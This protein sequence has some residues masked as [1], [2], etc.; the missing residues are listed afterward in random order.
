MQQQSDSL[1]VD[2]SYLDLSTV[3]DL[4]DIADTALNGKDGADIFPLKDANPILV[5]LSDTFQE[6]F[7]QSSNVVRVGY[8]DRKSELK[9]YGGRDNAY[10]IV[11]L[12]SGKIIF[13]DMNEDFNYGDV[14]SLKIIPEQGVFSKIEETRVSIEATSAPIY[15]MYWYME[16]R[17]MKGELAHDSRI[18]NDALNRYYNIIEYMISNGMK[19]DDILKRTYHSKR[20][21]RQLTDYLISK[22]ASPYA[23]EHDLNEAVHE[24]DY[25][26]AAYLIS[27]KKNTPLGVEGLEAAAWNGDLQMVKILVEGGAN[28]N[29]NKYGPVTLANEKGHMEI[30]KYLRAHGGKMLDR[31]TGNPF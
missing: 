27:K 25:E 19:L 6:A 23:L 17:T 2:R 29:A 24:K 11:P 12:G 7:H 18:S 8:V 26:E 9:L 14:L 31:E 30:V 4:F 13:N 15:Y 10:V 3:Q 1:T 20:S 21:D 22:G 28:V 5:K 16:R